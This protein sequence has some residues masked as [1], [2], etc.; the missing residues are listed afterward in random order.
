[1]LGMFQYPDSEAHKAFNLSLRCN[2]VDGT[3]GTTYLK[4]VGSHGSMDVQWDKII[5]KRNEVEEGDAF[6]AEKMKNISTQ[7]PRKKMLP[8]NTTVYDVETGYKG[9]HYDHHGYWLDAI[10]NNGKVVQD[11]VFGFR[12][13]APALLCNDSYHQNKFIDWDPIAMKV[14][15]EK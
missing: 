3:S 7:E 5:L 15:S 4:L 8:P 12:A 1:M 14:K 6:T 13:A 2:F 11:P 10:R 9:A